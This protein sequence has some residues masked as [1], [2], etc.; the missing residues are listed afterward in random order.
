MNRPVLLKTEWT[1]PVTGCRG[2]FVI[3]CLIDGSCGGGIRMRKGLD[4]N[5]V[6]RLA[7][8]M[9]YK[10]IGLEIPCGGS[11]GG[12]DFN[13]SD[14]ESRGVLKRFLEAHRPFLRECWITSEDLGTREED[15][16]ELLSEMGVNTSVH[17]V[18]AREA[19]PA[20]A[21]RG[22]LQA[23][24]ARV[25]GMQ[26]TDVVT[27]YGLAQAAAVA[28]KEMGRNPAGCTAAVQG[29]GS[30]GGSG[31]LYLQRLGLKVVAVA[32]ALGTVYSPDGLDVA[33]LLKNRS[34]TGEVDR[35]GLP[36]PYQKLDREQWLKLPVDVLVP[37]AVADAVNEDNVGEVKAG[38]IVEGANIPTTP[39]AEESL[40]RRGVPVVPDFIANSGGAGF[41][42]AVLF[43]RIYDSQGILDYLASQI[44][45]FTGAI[46]REAKNSGISLRQAAVRLVEQKLP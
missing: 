33:L 21:A 5:E 40:F 24:G 20:D 8:I 37:A 19:D 35:E 38:L 43:R 25:D 12:I 6:E 9:T 46:F 4:V 44:G 27:G 15:I 31:A 11:K 17:A 34:K 14:R 26:I 10:L 22:L 16:M 29:F 18:L 3:D 32:D 41:F 13:P 30:V 2:Y 7:R 39:G 28:L 1:D 23:L 36:G 42:G 45:D